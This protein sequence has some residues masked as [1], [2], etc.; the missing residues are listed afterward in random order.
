MSENLSFT[1]PQ[2][3]PAIPQPAL[4][5][6]FAGMTGNRL[7]ARLPDADFELLA[8]H[9]CKASFDQGSVLQE[10]GQAI[11]RAYFL[12]SG[13]V[14]LLA[15]LPDNHAVDTC[16]IGREGAI[17]LTA[18]LGAETSFS[19]AVV[20]IPVSAAQIPVERL[21]E[22][23]TR[24]KPVRDMI[25]RYS[26]ALLEQTQKTLACNT[27]HHVMQRLCRWLLQ[28]YER[29]GDD[30]LPV[31]Q[32]CLS[33]LLGVQRT[34]VT[35]M[36]RELQSQGIIKVRR[37]RIKIRDVRELE[38]RACGCNYATLAHE[39]THWKMPLIPLP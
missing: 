10:P 15:L 9:L 22:A 34:T 18:G 16:S 31:T 1:E 36:G 27:V 38:R 20:Q 29:T 21:A 12:E 30:T 25:I 5:S 8:R 13:L 39:I 35:M 11:T 33:T 3:R 19:R 32:A 6:G 4:D 37:G 23:A 7:L 17:G 24:S 28:A 2:A 14:S 26:D